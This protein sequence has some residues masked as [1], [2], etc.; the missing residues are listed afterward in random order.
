MALKK[1]IS[2]FYP[3][4]LVKEFE[5]EKMTPL[6]EELLIHFNEIWNDDLKKVA[7][8][9]VK[10]IEDFNPEQTI[11]EAIT[12]AK[13]SMDLAKKHNEILE[14]RPKYQKVINSIL[15]LVSKLFDNR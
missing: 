7:I 2:Y 13:T 11:I 12:E 1:S 9:L 3:K 4:Y 5:K 15:N 14:S 10:D 8:Q 6:E